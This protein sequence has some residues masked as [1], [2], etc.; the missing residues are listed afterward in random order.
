MKIFGL[1]YEWVMK[2]VVYECVLIYLMVLSFFEV[3]IFLVM[4]EVMLVLMCVVQFKCGWW[5]VIFSLVGLMV[6]V[7]VGYVLGYYVF[8]VIKLVFE[9]LGMF[10]VI[11]QGIIIVQVKMVELLWVVF[12]FLVL[13]GFMLILMKVFMWVLGIVG[14]LMLQ[15]LLSMLI[16]C[17]KCVFVLVVVICIGGVCVEVVLC[18][19]I[20][21]LGWIVIVL[22]VV[23]IVWFVWRLKFV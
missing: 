12:I 5:F 17:G 9:V 23:L 19:W 3:I 16:G 1:L 8:E 13:G 15:Y 4:L 6:G 2:W 7:L 10:L 14:V 11:E 22:V 21:L 20:E 18:C